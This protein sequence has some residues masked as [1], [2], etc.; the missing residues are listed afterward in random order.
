MS[1]KC[2]HRCSARLSRVLPSVQS[3]HSGDS[4]MIGD[5]WADC[6][7]T[8]HRDALNDALCILVDDILNEPEDISRWSAAAPPKFLHRCDG[9]FRRKFR[10]TLLTVGYEAL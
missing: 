7:A 4:K 2:C 5:A 10:V 6:L 9:L 1:S 3:E 8:S